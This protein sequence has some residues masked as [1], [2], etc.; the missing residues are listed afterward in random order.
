MIKAE[1][2]TKRSCP[3][4]ATRFYDLTKDDPITCINCGYAWVSESVLKS[5]QP[6]PFEEAQ[7]PAKVVAEPEPTDDLDMAVD[8]DE[9]SDSPDKDADLGGATD[10]G[11]P[12]GDKRTEERCGGTDGGSTWK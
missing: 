10:M 9:D 1:W 8:V 12:N 4:C 3:K 6:M 11:H 5:K 2:G 7:K